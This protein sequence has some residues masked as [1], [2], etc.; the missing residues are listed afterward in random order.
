VPVDLG[1]RLPMV[2]PPES[3]GSDG[4]SAGG[5]SWQT[6]PVLLPITA[7]VLV[8]EAERLGDDGHRYTSRQLYYAVCRAVE[9]PAYSITRGFIG[10]GATLIV[11][12]G[13]MLWVKTVPLSAILAVVGGAL[14]LAAPLNARVERGREL[15]RSLDSRT[16]AISYP[17]FVAGPLAEALRVWPEAFTALV[18]SPPADGLRAGSPAADEGTAQLAGHPAGHPAPG[19]LVVCDRRE[20]AELLAANAGRLPGGTGFSVL[21]ALPTDDGGQLAPG[22]RHRRLVAVHDADP[23]GCGLPA[24]LRRAGASD[25]ADAGLRCPA[26]DVGLQV[27]EGAP[28]RLPAG[29]ESDLTASELVW[30]RSGRRLELATLTPREVLELVLAACSP[31]PT[32]MPSST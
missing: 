29:V 20:T 17:S 30:L 31:A 32:G 27:I 2:A 21:E 24:A 6:R 19:C 8:D 12:A 11:L 14:V 22:I 15:R 23:A 13:A 28:A 7:G 18:A 26:S 10:L 9:R 4:A 16:L 5:D 1:G 25:I 3:R